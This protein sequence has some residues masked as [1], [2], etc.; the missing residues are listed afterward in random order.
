MGK[1]IGKHGRIAQAIRVLMRT[2]AAENGQKVTV[3][4][5]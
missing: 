3:D 4:I 1:V 5:E 2:A